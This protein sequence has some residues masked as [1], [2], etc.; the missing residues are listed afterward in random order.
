MKPTEVYDSYWL[1]A[2]ERLAIYY[3]KQEKAEGPWTDDPIL[4]RFRF[5]NTYRAAD[6]VSQYLIR[7]VQYAPCRSTAPADLFFRT[8]LFKLFNRIATWEA[9]ESA[10]GPVEWRPGILDKIEPVL[11]RLMRHGQRIYSAAYIMPAPRLGGVRKHANHL[12]LMKQMMDDRLADRLRQAPDLAAVYEMLLRYPGLGRFLAFQYAID[13]NYS[14]MLDFS[15][16]EFVVAGPGAIDGISKCFEDYG[17]YRP[18]DIIYT[19]TERQHE[20]FRRL[21]IAFP[22]LHGRPLQPI[23]CQ[24]VFCEIS[25]YARVAHPQVRGTADRTR[26]KQVYKPSSRPT[27]PPMYPPKWK[28]HLDQAE[29]LRGSVQAALFQRLDPAYGSSLYG[30]PDRPPTAKSGRPTF[31]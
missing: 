23:D 14:E 30:G 21:G 11:D 22:G 3:Q 20:E 15:E 2:A 8:L 26:I 25:K 10:V 1:F 13:L 24:N 6:R 9:I 4:A 5:T 12:A 16:S 18:E 27:L 17:R 31:R 7:D 19:M 28:I 29:A